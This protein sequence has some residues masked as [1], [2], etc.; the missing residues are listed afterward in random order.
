MTTA[1]SP[2]VVSAPA[3]AKTHS[4]WASSLRTSLGY[5]RTKVGLVITGLI[6]LI[7][8][9]GPF[10]APHSPSQLVGPPF[11]GSSGSAILGTDYVGEDVFSRVLAGGRYI[12]WMATGA[13]LIGVVGGTALGVIA[14]Y[15]RRWADEAI[16]RSLDVLLAVPVLVFLLMF[17]AM[18]GSSPVLIMFLVGVA[19]VPTVARTI[20][21]ATAEISRREFIEAAQV[22]GTPR[23][24]I[25][26][27]DVLPN[28]MTLILVEFGLRCAWSI[29]LVAVVNYLGFGVS[30]P[31]ADW[32]LMV[33][34]NVVG[35]A[36]QPWAVVAPIVCIALFSIGV[37]L[38]ADGLSVA[39]SGSD[40]RTVI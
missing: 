36:V 11:H 23:R 17:I 38:L 30:P 25:L 19:W 26:V 21:A 34:E 6:L 7:A 2:P 12:V 1:A 31:R 18:L 14:G 27:H 3:P 9:F 15:S 24:R 4:W 40:R 16:M 20:R 22:I 5:T 28:L 32:G 13:A 8:I 35:A 37:S 10:L 33:N 29:S 39:I